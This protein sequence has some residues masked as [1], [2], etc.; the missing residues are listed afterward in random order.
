M[1]SDKSDS[2]AINQLERDI[3][4]LEVEARVLIRKQV[5]E[6]LRELH[7]EELTAVGE[8][9]NVK[10]ARLTTLERQRM[11][12][13]GAS[14]GQHAALAKLQTYESVAAFWEEPGRVV[15]QVLHALFGDYRMWVLDGEII[16][17]SLAPP[18]TKSKRANGDR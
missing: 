1:S 13:E 7:E 9:L 10:K 2:S 12:R 16:R 8:E 18:R 6:A 11:L 15:N 4:N 14:S 5:P 17:I 3:R